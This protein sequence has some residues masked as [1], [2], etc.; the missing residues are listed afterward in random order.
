MHHRNA[1]Y[2]ALEVNATLSRAYFFFQVFRIFL[3][4]VSYFPITLT[5]TAIIT[6]HIT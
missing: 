3:S 6:R 5:Q 4:F 1:N 2:F